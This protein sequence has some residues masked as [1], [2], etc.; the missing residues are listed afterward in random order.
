MNATA[1]VAEFLLER[2]DR[3]RIA[4]RHITENYSYGRLLDQSAT[5]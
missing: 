5:A 3:S 4:L 2:Q 1:N